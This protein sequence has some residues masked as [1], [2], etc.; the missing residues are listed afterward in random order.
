MADDTHSRSCSWPYDKTYDTQSFVGHG[1]RVTLGW[2]CHTW[3]APLCDI[4]NLWSSYF[5]VP[6]TTLHHLLNDVYAVNLNGLRV[7]ASNSLTVF[8]KPGLVT[9]KDVSLIMRGRLYSSC[10]RSSMLLGSETW[11][12]RKENVVALQRAE[13]RM[14]RWMCGIKLKDRLPSKELR[15][16]LGID[17]IALV[18]QQNRLHWYGM[19]CKKKMMIGWRNIWSWGSKTKRK[20]KEDLERGC[21]RGLSSM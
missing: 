16:I 17:E 13:M 14:V 4:F 11:P 6:L 8:G 21:T 9:Y 15:E 3:A 18:L 7:S 10:V 20:T 1:N 5:H 2:K 19:C 12:L